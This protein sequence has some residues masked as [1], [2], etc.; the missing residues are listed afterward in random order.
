VD[1]SDGLIRQHG[2]HLIQAGAAVSH[3]ALR[4]ANQDG[5]AGLYEASESSSTATCFRR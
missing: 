5:F 2:K 3:I 4:A 1:F